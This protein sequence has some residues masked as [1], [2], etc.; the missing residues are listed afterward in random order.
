MYILTSEA[1]QSIE[2]SSLELI[3]ILIQ[4]LFSFLHRASQSP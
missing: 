3:V 1:V 4:D 2:M